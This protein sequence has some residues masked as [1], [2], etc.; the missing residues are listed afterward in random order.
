VGV[1]PLRTDN[2]F[3]L[4]TAFD[5]SSAPD[6]AAA[7]R[8]LMRAILRSAIEDLKRS[9]EPYRQARKYFLSNDEDYLFS[10][11]CICNHLGI[12]PVTIR[13]RLGLHVQHIHERLAA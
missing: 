5:D 1:V 8:K 9:G 4:Y 10:F 6:S 3:S 13:T 7:E 2:A 11:I 12:C